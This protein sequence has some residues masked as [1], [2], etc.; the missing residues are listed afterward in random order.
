[1]CII[2]VRFFCHFS[3]SL[4]NFRYFLK[5]GYFLSPNLRT[6]FG[7]K[8]PYFDAGQLTC[9]QAFPF[10]PF[11]FSFILC[12]L[13]WRQ[14]FVLHFSELNGWQRA[15]SGENVTPNDFLSFLVEQQRAILRNGNPDYSAVSV[16]FDIR[17]KPLNA[18]F[19]YLST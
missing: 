14:S 9:L 19:T 13:R 8:I 11:V 16:L 15:V 3:N 17:L 7:T 6:N 10:L 2:C 4:V 18:S 12:Q 1:M 5:F